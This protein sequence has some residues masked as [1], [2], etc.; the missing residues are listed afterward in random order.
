LVAR[1]IEQR[2]GL[3][4]GE[5]ARC[6]AVAELH[7]GQVLLYDVVLLGRDRRGRRTDTR[8][9]A[10]DAGHTGDACVAADCGSADARAADARAAA[11]GPADA[12]SADSGS[13]TTG[14]TPARR[15]ASAAR[16][17]RTG[18]DPANADTGAR[19]GTRP[20]RADAGA[21]RRATAR[22]ASA[23]T[24]NTYAG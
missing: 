6:D 12:G 14:C 16:A 10:R 15:S 4:R 24:A 1:A 9:T 23:D 19:T 2:R 20:G 22:S 7:V 17:T 21:G 3:C 11:S 13:A 8:R 18:A 5:R